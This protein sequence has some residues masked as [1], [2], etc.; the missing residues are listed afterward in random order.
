MSC[1][2]AHCTPVNIL[3]RIV[4]RGNRARVKLV[5]TSKRLTIACTSSYLWRLQPARS[6]QAI[7][8]SQRD[9]PEG[10]GPQGQ[11]NSVGAIRAGINDGDF[12]DEDA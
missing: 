5:H 9:A 11:K 6:L 12:S 3:L 2:D 7:V 8:Y 10:T 4:L 1:N